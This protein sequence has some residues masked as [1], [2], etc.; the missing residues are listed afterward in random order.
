MPETPETRYA[1]LEND[2][3]AYQVLGEGPPNLLWLGPWISHIDGRW[4]DPCFRDP[5]RRI[6]RFSRLVAFDK[7]GS[8]ASDRF[9]ADA[10]GT[11]EDWVQDVRAVMRA[12]G[13]GRAVVCGVADGG[14]V[15]ALLAATYPEL[16]S[17]LILVNTAARFTQTEDYPW[18]VSDELAEAVIQATRETWGN[19]AQLDLTMP[20]KVSDVG[21]RRW[22]NRY[23]RMSASPAT[24]ESQLRIM[25]GSDCRHALP[26]VH[27]PTLVIHRTEI[28]A[29][30]VEHGR[31]LADHIEGAKLVELPGA[32]VA[33]F[34]GDSD[35]IVDAI[36]EFVTGHPAVRVPDRAFATVLMT[37]MVEST[38]LA[39]RLGDA[40]WRTVI[41]RHD[42]ISRSI[43]ERHAGEVVKATGDGVLATFD[44]SERALHCSI[45]LREELADLG[46]S[47]R[48]GIH[49]GEVELRDPD[50]GGLTVH[51]TSRVTALAEPNEILV[52]EALRGLIVGSPFVLQDRG[53]HALKGLPGQWHVFAATCAPTGVI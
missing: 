52:T 9:P 23:Q 51:I 5:L 41:D 38:D 27:V 44:G 36:E 16:V 48:T 35:A 53:R 30:P 29:I 28:A 25:L 24:A 6:A 19:G 21:F 47:I 4:E 13:S 37:D 46:V 18:G 26:A 12:A 39:V 7:R 8:G 45:A 42:A 34:A 40:Q 17:Q 14:P 32:D 31:Y 20:S 1:R 2:R 10:A 49:A 50:I 43:V 3:I 15:A 33:V 22:W 11:W